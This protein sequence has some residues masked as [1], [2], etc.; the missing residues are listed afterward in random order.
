MLSP[1]FSRR[2][3]LMTFSYGGPQPGF[4]CDSHGHP[5]FYYDGT[6]TL[7]LLTCIVLALDPGTQSFSDVF[8]IGAKAYP[9]PR[10]VTLTP[11]RILDTITED[12]AIF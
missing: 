1:D 2:A 11:Q 9:R 12:M 6:P 8:V 7:F 4:V 3:F 10:G 5:L